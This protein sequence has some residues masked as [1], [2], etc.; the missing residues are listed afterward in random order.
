M[1]RA[2]AALA[3][4]VLPI[5]FGCGNVAPPAAAKGA[6][7][8]TR[9]IIRTKSGVEMVEIP[10]GTFEM[11]SRGRGDET[12]HSVKLDAIYMDRTEVTQEQFR[13]LQIGDPSHFK[14]PRNPVEMISWDRAILFCNER[15]NAEGLTPCYGEDR[16]CNFAADGYRLPTEAEWEYPCR[17]GGDKDYAYGADPRML[18]D[19]AWFKDNAGKKTHP[20]AQKHPNAWGRYDMH[21]NAAEW[22]NDVYAKDYFKAGAAENPRGPAAGDKRVLRGGAWESGANILR[23]SARVGEAPGFQDACFKLDAIGFRCV[24]RK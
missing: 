22:C 11:G 17:A 14:D 18:G 5:F 10:A 15:S 6:A 16:V 7:G 3:A 13:T 2:R 9:A 8:S 23:C 20:V 12:P 24:R 19:H 1:K 21:G 4:L